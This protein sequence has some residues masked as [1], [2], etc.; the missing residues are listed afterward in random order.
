M[1]HSVKEQEYSVRVS[2]PDKCWM[3]NLPKKITFMML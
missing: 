1:F 2:K 3:A